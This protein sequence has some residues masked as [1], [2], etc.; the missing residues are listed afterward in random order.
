MSHPQTPDSN[1][2]TRRQWLTFQIERTGIHDT[3]DNSVCDRNPEVCSP[4]RLQHFSHRAMGCT[5]QVLV[6][7]DRY[8]QA[9]QLVMCAFEEIDRWESILSIYR[10]D[11]ELSRI[12]ALAAHQWCTMSAELFTLVQFAMEL[13]RQTRGAYDPTSTELSRVWG[14]L[15]GQPRLPDEATL[16]AARQL[17]GYSHVALRPDD[18]AIQFERLGLTLNFN[19]IGKGFA[20]QKVAEMLTAA[21]V[22]DFIIHGGQSSVVARGNCELQGTRSGWQVGL[23]HPMIPNQRLAEFTLVGESLG[24]SGSQR[25]AFFSD[26]KRYGHV[27]DPRTGWPADHVAS[28]TV[29][30]DNAAVCDALSTACFVMGEDEIELFCAEHAEVK[31]V[32]SL[33]VS[34]GSLRLQTWNLPNVE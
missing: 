12:N 22:R 5:F 11:S 6:P 4:V 9:A 24:T 25:Q 33:P 19:G 16:V 8:P 34:G 28:A 1:L 14:F 31:V 27:L 13:A 7:A 23:S 21:G 29:I 17:V 26:G 15:D 20:L 2:S 30:H 10:T 3:V 32:R 18:H